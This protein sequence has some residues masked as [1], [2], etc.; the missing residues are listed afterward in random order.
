[1]VYF[2][3]PWLYIVPLCKILITIFR[4]VID[5]GNFRNRSWGHNRSLLIIRST[6]RKRRG[7]LDIFRRSCWPLIDHFQEGLDFMMIT[8]NFV[9]FWLYFQMFSIKFSIILKL[10]MAWLQSV[11]I[12]IHFKRS[13]IFVIQIDIKLSYHLRLDMFG[14]ASEL[15]VTTSWLNGLLHEWLIMVSVFL[16]VER[17]ILIF[18]I[19]P[20][21]RY[22][23]L[24]GDLFF[25]EGRATILHF[26]SKI[27]NC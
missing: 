1:M 21:G 7:N 13:L 10:A 20:S 9:Q 14:I 27:N 3:S 15:R 24:I 8:L 17:K 26:I 5:R 2:R 19:Y 18:S 11:L 25:S 4:S 6:W 22:G 12:L 23:E 16:F